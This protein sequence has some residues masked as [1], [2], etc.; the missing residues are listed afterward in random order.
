MGDAS[1]A[2]GDYGGVAY[3]GGYSGNGYGYGGGSDAYGDQGWVALP[4]DNIFQGQNVQQT[5]FGPSIDG[6]DMLEVLLRGN[7]GS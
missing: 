4:L 2:G 3:A 7:M 5:G 6:D 1:M